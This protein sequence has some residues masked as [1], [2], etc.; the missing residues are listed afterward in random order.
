MK[1]MIKML[2]IL[3]TFCLL[4]GALPLSVYAADVDVAALG[5]QIFVRTLTGKTVTLEVESSD[6]IENIKQKIQEKEAIPPD[7]QRLIFAG[8]QLEDGRTLADYNIQKESTLHLVLR[9]TEDEYDLWVGDTRVTVDNCHEIPTVTGGKASFDPTTS[10]L[11]LE[12]VKGIDGSYYGSLIHSRLRDLY[13]DLKGENT[14]STDSGDLSLEGIST[15]GNLTISGSENDR[16]FFENLGTAI[17]TTDK[18]LTV[19]GGEIHQKSRAVNTDTVHGELLGMTVIRCGDMTVKGGLIDLNGEIMMFDTDGFWDFFFCDIIDCSS[20]EMNGGSVYASFC[21]R[22]ITA[23]NDLAV[24][25]GLILVL[26]AMDVGIYAGAISISGSQTNIIDRCYNIAMT[27]TGGAITVSDEVDLIQPEDGTIGS[28]YGKPA[29]VN[30][31]G[32]GATAVT[33]AS[34]CTAVFHDRDGSVLDTADYY[35]GFAAETESTPADYSDSSADYYFDHW[36]QANAVT[37]N[38]VTHIYPV[39]YSVEKPVITVV[40]GDYGEDITVTANF[41]DTVFDTL[42]NAGVYDTL[43][44]MENEDHLF[45]EF[46]SKPIEEFESEDEYYDDVND[47]ADTAVSSDMVVYA[48]FFKK[49]RSVDLMLSRPH[50]GDNVTV[51]DEGQEP[52]P[53]IRIPKSSYC[54]VY[55]AEL[56][57]ADESGELS[58]FEGSF[59]AGKTYYLTLLLAPEL[60]WWLDDNTV[61]N[62]RG[63]ELTDSY[64]RLY[65][66]A[67]MAF[68]PLEPGTDDRY[69]ML[70]DADGNEKVDI[71]DATIVQRA[72]TGLNVDRYEA[73]LLNGDIDSSS[74][75][76]VVDAT[77][78]QRFATGLGTP[79]Q[80]GEWFVVKGEG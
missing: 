32:S 34:P 52:A 65:L 29:I 45:R 72:A 38:G 13:I 14:L 67:E 46:T 2:A 9:L 47:L 53:D 49:V 39:Y 7:Q 4:M 1:K 75:P 41:G 78:I 27:T 43:D 11:T 79:Y 15:W 8:K 40:M 37:E 63:G 66:V 19:E 74:S 57:G 73:F 5:M 64:G 71:I 6:T 61:V 70:G 33:L 21:N 22:A 24:N 76:D 23:Q 12:N 69:G 30:S 16:L 80:I 10:T 26:A 35:Y 36:D 54:S 68:T 56:I 59:D 25:S 20:F 51:T 50:I 44:A 58:Y 77:F 17:D 31:D 3:L 48:C 60:G 42:Y 62:T 18:A 28:W 55:S